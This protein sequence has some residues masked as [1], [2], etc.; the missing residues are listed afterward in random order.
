MLNQAITKFFDGRVEAAR[1]L[2]SGDLVLRVDS[3]RTRQDLHKQS[4]WTEALGPGTRLNK[5]WFT[6]LVKSVHL[7]AFDCSNQEVA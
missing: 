4:G 5:P 6:V 2:P 3:K 1:A 7:D